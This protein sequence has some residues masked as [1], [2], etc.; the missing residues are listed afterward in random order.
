MDDW[1]A[2]KTQHASFAVASSATTPTSFPSGVEVAQ[3]G[4]AEDHAFWW[5]VDATTGS[6]VGRGPGGYGQ[7]DYGVMLRNAVTGIKPYFK[8]GLVS[9]NIASAVKACVTNTV[10]VDCAMGIVGL[11]A[12][13]YG[14]VGA[15]KAAQ[16]GGRVGNIVSVAQHLLPTLPD[17]NVPYPDPNAPNSCGMV[18]A[19]GDPA[20]SDGDGP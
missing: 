10:S 17:S 9:Y 15:T 16:A 11:M 8:A 19:P 20:A 13:G 2:A 6:A 14:A 7:S 18:C 3:S 1:L 5:D 4:V 12:M